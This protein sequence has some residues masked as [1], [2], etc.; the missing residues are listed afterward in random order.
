MKPKKFLATATLLLLLFMQAGSA[1]AQ[2]P[3]ESDT[4][5]AIKDCDELSPLYPRTE[6]GEIDASKINLSAPYQ[7]QFGLNFR[8]A[9]E[10]A[11]TSYHAYMECV[12]ENT[13]KIML[14]SAGGSAKSEKEQE[15]LIFSANAPNLPEW[16]KPET[17]CPSNEKGL[18]ETLK[19]GSPEALVKP[20]LSTY[21]DYVDYLNLLFGLV[22][23]RISSNESGKTDSFD[24]M[25]EKNK[26]FKLLVENEIQ[27]ALAALD[28]AFIGLKEMR[29]AYMMH[30]HFQCMLKNLEVYRHAME[31]LRKVIS[32]LPSVIINASIH[33]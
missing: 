5:K 21:N 26:Y 33:K 17:A 12:F 20:L 23:N 3:A 7:G 6:K 29:Q 28:G 16:M 10:K 13:V 27:D 18:V 32:A 22:S 24:V 31:N 11:R 4:P 9:F 2:T 30:V 25:A 1:M 19:G 15:D 14:N 8:L